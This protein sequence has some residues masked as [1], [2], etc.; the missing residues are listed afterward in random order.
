[1]VNTAPRI[2]VT[3]EL[4]WQLCQVNP[5]LRLERTAT[6]ELIVN[7]PTGGDTGNRNADLIIDFG[8][9]NRKNKLGK[10][11]DSSTGFKLPNGATRSPDVSWVRLDRWTGLSPEQRR[12]FL[13]LAPDFVLELMSPSDKLTDVQEKLEEYM[14]NG[15]L[16]GWLINPDGKT[17][18][19]YHRGQP[20]Q[21]LRIPATLRGEAV[22]P[23]F[24]LEV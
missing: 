24:E 9:W 8:I 7:P 6:G 2:Y 21:L 4:F 20:V 22:L 10:L 17:V 13:P 3:P 18:E 16:L 14:E 15:V 5:E 11:F 19:I 12:G 23:G 1:M